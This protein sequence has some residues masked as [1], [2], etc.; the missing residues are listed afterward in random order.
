MKGIRI[1][2]FITE[3]E[4]RI[5]QE[6][7]DLAIAKAFHI[8]WTRRGDSPDTLCIHHHAVAGT[9]TSLLKTRETLK[10]YRMTSG[11]MWGN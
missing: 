2:I 8:S 4:D 11:E 9:L 5:Q 1:K 7:V 10:G 6:Q 3:L